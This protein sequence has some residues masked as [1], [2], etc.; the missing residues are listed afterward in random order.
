MVKYTF[1]FLTASF[2][3]ALALLGIAWKVVV[4]IASLISHASV[5]D[6]DPDPV[7]REPF[8]HAVSGGYWNH[9]GEWVSVEVGD[10]RYHR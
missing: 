5:E 1:R 6:E 10:P 9:S 2:F 8:A 3:L 4:T 7:Y